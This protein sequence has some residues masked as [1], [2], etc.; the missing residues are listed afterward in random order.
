MLV[1]M[2]KRDG[3]ILAFVHFAVTELRPLWLLWYTVYNTFENIVT[4]AA[5]SDAYLD[6]NILACLYDERMIARDIEKCAKSAY[7]RYLTHG[8][9]SIYKECNQGCPGSGVGIG[10]PEPQ[11]MFYFMTVWLF[12]FL[13]VLLGYCIYRRPDYHTG[14]YIKFTQTLY[15]S[16]V[17]RIAAFC[18]FVVSFIIISIG[19]H[20]LIKYDKGWTQYIIALILM[21]MASRSLIREKSNGLNISS[22]AFCHTKIS[23]GNTFMMVINFFF[24]TN[25]ALLDQVEIQF[26]KKWL[27]EDLAAPNHP[28]TGWSAF[29]TYNPLIEDETTKNSGGLEN[30]GGDN[31]AELPQ[32]V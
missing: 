18:T 20:L 28:K 4:S 14:S 5:V 26:M 2:G 19:I 1:V 12:G 8:P 24:T 10:V 23:R 32:R 13:L 27:P 7:K 31:D 15:V 9:Q 21:V 29:F 25:A 3:Q 17:Y 30:K 6:K 22:E 11:S 16:K